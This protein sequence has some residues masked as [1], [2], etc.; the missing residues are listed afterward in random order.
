MEKA[1]KHWDGMPIPGMKV[2]D[3][4]ALAIQAYRDKA[5][6]NGRHTKSEVNVSDE[7]IVSDLKL[8]DE[9]ADGNGDIMRAAM[10]LFHSDPE[11]Y[12]TGASVK[13]AFLL[14]KARMVITNRM[15]SF[16]MMRYMAH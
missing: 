5:V 7:Q 2:S 16:I 1:G 15:I 8:I 11:K 4:D 13:I 14:R 9:S 3:L 6:E 12:V 10:L